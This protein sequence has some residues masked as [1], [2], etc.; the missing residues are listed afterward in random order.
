MG[1]QILEEISHNTEFF[2]SFIK[3]IC[4][5]PESETLINL[6]ILS[7]ISLQKR[8]VSQSITPDD[9]KVLTGFEEILIKKWYFH[10]PN[11]H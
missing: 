5:L 8:L 6:W 3:F 7:Y 11:T 4:D 9:R 10:I 2:G 1:A